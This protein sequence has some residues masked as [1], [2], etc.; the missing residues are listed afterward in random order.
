MSKGRG[1]EGEV[2][3]CFV[4]KGEELIAAL[5]KLKSSTIVPAKINFGN[6]APLRYARHKRGTSKLTL[7]MWTLVV[8]G[9]GLLCG[10]VV[11][12]RIAS[13]SVPYTYQTVDKL[14]QN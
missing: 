8:W 4:S 2:E 12:H 7:V 6:L 9:V 11:I 13:V 14:T 3:T 10:L 5:L 1:A